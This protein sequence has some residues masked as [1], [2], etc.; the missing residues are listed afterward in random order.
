[1]AATM[2]C[3]VSFVRADPRKNPDASLVV[4]QL[5]DSAL[6]GTGLPL[7]FGLEYVHF[8]AFSENPDA[9][10]EWVK[11]YITEEEAKRRFVE[12]GV[13]FTVLEHL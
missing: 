3:W 12:L 5:G 10:W 6:P 1:M 11:Y 13:G 9:A 7:P 2:I 8:R 4:G